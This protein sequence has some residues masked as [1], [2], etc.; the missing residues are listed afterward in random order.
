MVLVKNVLT[1]VET[2]GTPLFSLNLSKCSHALQSHATSSSGGSSTISQS[3]VEQKGSNLIQH[4]RQKA[5]VARN[6]ITIAYTYSS[7]ARVIGNNASR[8]RTFS[9]RKVHLTL[10]CLVFGCNLTTHT[11]QDLQNSVRQACTSGIQV[12]AAD[13]PPAAFNAMTANIAWL[14]DDDAWKTV[15]AAFPKDQ[16][17]HAAQVREEF[18]KKKAQGHK[19]LLLLSVRDDRTFLFT[20]R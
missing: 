10:L 5:W 19:L 3:S 1:G 12:L 6:R 13:V 4:L 2:E 11:A 20:L 18:V 17:S 9:L 16:S 14:A 7:Q 15:L 8:A